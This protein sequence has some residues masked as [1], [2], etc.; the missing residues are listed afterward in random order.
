MNKQWVL[1]AV[2]VLAGVMLADRI[3]ALP[4]G[5]RLPTF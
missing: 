2:L 1:Y 5:N 3:R 4:G